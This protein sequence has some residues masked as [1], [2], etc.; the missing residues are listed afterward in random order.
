MKYVLTALLLLHGLIHLLGFAKAFQ[1]A[2]LKEFMKPISRPAGILWLLA[3]VMFLTVALLYLLR[4]EAW[5]WLLAAAMVLSQVLIFFWWKDARFGTLA[6]LL[7]LLPL[8]TG[9]AIHRFKNSF[10]AD[11]QYNLQHNNPVPTNRVTEA[12]LAPLPPPVQRYLRYAGV[13]NK[14]C[15]VNMYVAFEGEM[16]SRE[17]NWFPFR[18]EQ[19]NF[20][21]TAA[22]LFFM[23]AAPGGFPAAVY[24]RYENAAA[25]M[26]IRAA[27]IKR[28]VF[29]KGTVLNKTETVTLF[30]DMCLLAPAT[31][32]DKRI[33]WE[34]GD[35]LSARA[36]FTNQGSTISAV[37]YFNE[38]G[39]LIDFISNDRTDVSSGKTLTFSTPVQ[40]YQ[41][42]G[43][44]RLPAY[45][46]AIW[47][48]PEGPFTYGK[49]RLKKVTYNVTALQ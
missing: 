10:R 38:A 28:V 37:L 7:L 35:S 21:E 1:L 34:D 44:Y 11:V 14:P 3:T 9:I 19:Y 36:T 41:L 33:S 47:H 42:F 20:I 22:R 5:V 29:E 30:N 40:D 48:Y 2:E 25:V 4:H 13:V 32:I 27:G 24:H 31:L 17:Q 16:R 23:E 49:F 26:D 12:D 39:A 8:V 43:E 6:N 45:G 15:V 46:E 18:S